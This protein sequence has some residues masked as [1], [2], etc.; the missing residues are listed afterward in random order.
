M[1]IDDV[2][3]PHPKKMRG[4]PRGGETMVIGLP[5]KQKIA[6]RPVPFIRK[7]P[8]EK[9]ASTYLLVTNCLPKQLRLACVYLFIYLPN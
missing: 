3:L 5:K 2:K 1:L 6:A 8:Q 4:R 9:E 7:S